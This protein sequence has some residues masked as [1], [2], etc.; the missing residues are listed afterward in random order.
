MGSANLGNLNGNCYTKQECDALGGT[1]AGECAEGYGVCCVCKI[2]KKY[3]L[4]YFLSVKLNSEHFSHNQLWWIVVSEH[5]N[6][7][8]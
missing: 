5:H 7:S 2:F 8:K 6:L 1:A 4:F 3:I